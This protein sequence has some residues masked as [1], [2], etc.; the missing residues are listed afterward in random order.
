MEEAE[1]LCTRVAIMDSGKILKVDPPQKLI[2]DN[3]RFYRL[4]FLTDQTINKE[5]FN[6]IPEFVSIQSHLPK[7]VIDLQSAEILPDILKV[8]NDNKIPYNYLT[9]KTA[10]LEDVY[11]KL[12]GH[13]YKED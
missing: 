7:V 10:S 8:L 3:A 12:T 5:V 2:D 11:L 1:Y 6:K 9:L 4:S 13:E